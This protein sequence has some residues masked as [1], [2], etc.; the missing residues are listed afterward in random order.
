MVSLYEVFKDKYGDYYISNGK[1]HRIKTI[2][3]NN[4]IIQNDID[5]L[6]S[7][8]FRDGM[9]YSYMKRLED[10]LVKYKIVNINDKRYI[11]FG[12]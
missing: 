4:E 6:F 10:M 5:K 9:V 8:S 2:D 1:K 11:Q 7:A 3:K 12:G